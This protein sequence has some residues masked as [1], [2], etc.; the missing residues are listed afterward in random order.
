MIKKLFGWLFH[1]VLLTLLALIVVALLIWWIGPLVRIGELAPLESELSRAVL[2]GAIVLLVLLR[3]AWRRWRVRKASQHLTD[4]LMKAPAAPAAAGE[5]GGERKVLDARFTDAVATLKKMRLHAAGRKPGWRDWLSLSGGSYLYDLPWYVFIGAPGAGKTTALVNSGLSF[6]LAE[7]FGPGAIRGIGGTRNCDW[8][9]TDDAVLI[10]TAGRYTTQDSHQTEDKGAWESFLGLLKKVRPRRPLNGVFLT[11][12]VQDLLSHNAEQRSTLAASIRARLLELDAKL[13]TRLPVYVLVTKSDLLYGFGEYF[14][15]L[16]K[17]Q[18]AQV[19]GF[20]LPAEEGAV[21]DEKGLTDAFHREFGLLHGRVN[22]ALIQRMQRETD[23]T[24]RAAIFG[25]PAQ[26]GSIEPLLADLLEQ[27]FTGSRFTQPPWVRGVY[28]TSGTQEGSPIDRVMGALSRSFGLERAILPPQKSSGRSYF[29]TS[30]LRDVVFPEQRLAGADVK[31]ER[32]RHG[33]RVAALAAMTL[34]TLALLAGWGWSGWRNLE[35]LKAVDARIAPARQ[36]LAALPARVQNLVEVAPVLQGLRNIWKVPENRDGDEPLSM[37]L[38]LYQGNKLDAAAMLSHQRA[39]NEVFLPQLAKRIEDQLRTA[40]KDNLEFTYEALKT[41]LMLH[42]PDRFDAEAL[43]AWITLDWAR[44]LDRGIPEDQR[45]LLEDQLDVLIAQGP[46]RSPLKMD[47]AL[48]RNVRAVLASYPLEQRVFSRLKRQRLGKDI[49]PFSVAAAAGPAGPLVFE[50]ASGKPL[51]DGVPGMF[52][53]DGYHK[54][55]QNEVTVVT[56]LLATEDPWVLGQERGAADRLRDAAALGALTDRVRRLY[57]EE[58]AKVWEALLADV[59]LVRATG[60]DKNIENA[61]ILSGV[62][63]PLASFL[64]AVVKET[65]LTPAEQQGKDVVTKASETVRNT[66]KG[67]E[68]LFGGDP[69]K[70]VAAGKRIESI[71]DDRFADLRR[72]VSSPTPGGPAPIDD[73]LKLFNEV[74]VYLTA[75]D[76]AVKNR[77]SPP[78]GDVAGKL[79]SDAGRLPEP[80]RSMVENLSQTGATQ[81]RVAER[82]SLSLDLRPVTEFCKSAI[83]GRYPFVTSSKRDVLPEDFGQMFGPGGLMDEFFQKRLAALVDT[84]TRPWRYKPVAEQGAITAQAIAQFERAARIKEIFFRA[85]GRTPAMRLDFRPVEMDAGITQFILDVD[86]QLVK[87]AHGPVV[88]MAVQWP[89]PKGTNQ[90]RVQVSPPSASGPSGTAV[91]GPWALFR[92]LDEG[93][94]EAGDAPEKFFITFQI[95]ARKTRF[96]VTTNS[97]QHPIRLRELREF[98][99]PEGL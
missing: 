1:P 73:T 76:T 28:F 54:R 26:F 13:A 22:D 89:G 62:G 95:G 42:Q 96:E 10:D 11:V 34:V 5:D 59:R 45:K 39:L 32:R 66:R 87:Y 68:E 65:T 27:V 50:R 48:V 55:F 2:I 30:L 14:A 58:Y 67:L 85:A 98:A 78:P 38:G 53:Y 93:Q 24:R 40:Q 72:L 92:V 16:G 91:D 83:A 8:W 79:K 51:A 47:E 44:N 80:V 49:P 15:D 37:T 20:T 82:G 61:R 6:P 64:R 77:S 84:S 4:G 75:V 21:V 81:A 63:S 71:V 46:P 3:A 31:L 94:L 86:G 36:Q 90:V 25:F 60:L 74:Y 97:V 33:L 88:P 9:F 70:P 52:T 43:K 99:C 29:L 23:G 57:L 35:Y 69:N 18:R 56:G 7:K 17:E 12:S 19:F 41:Y